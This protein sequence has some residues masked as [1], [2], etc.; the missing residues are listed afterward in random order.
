MFLEINEA[1]RE[2][3]LEIKQE[4]EVNSDTE[5]DNANTENEEE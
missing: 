3:I 2:M 4:S 1:I 5:E